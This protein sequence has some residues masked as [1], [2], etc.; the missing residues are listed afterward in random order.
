MR[1]AVTISLVSEARGGPFVFW[2]DFADGCRQA[3][4][5][6]FDAV[7]VFPPDAETLDELRAAGLI[8]RPPVD[9]SG[10]PF[11]YDR[12]SGTVRV[13]RQSKLWRPDL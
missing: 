4:E 7:E 3:A 1:S 5:L 9:V 13:A 6:G 2:D 8:R 12:E 10:V 11:L